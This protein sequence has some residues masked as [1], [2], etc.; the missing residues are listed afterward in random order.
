MQDVFAILIVAAAAAFLARKAWLHITRRRGGACGTC[1]SCGVNDGIKAKPLVTVS[2]GRNSHAE[3]Q[4]RG[5][6]A[7]K[8]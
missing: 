6:K 4:S 8:R 1:G 7:E 3:A 2:I 5:E